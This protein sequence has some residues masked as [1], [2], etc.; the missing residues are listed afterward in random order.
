MTFRFLERAAIAGLLAGAGCLI[1]DALTH[2]PT[3]FYRYVP[4]LRPGR[5][6]WSHAEAL[7]NSRPVLLLGLL[8]LC[9][10]LLLALGIMVTVF[11]RGVMGHDLSTGPNTGS[12]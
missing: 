9:S 10:A 4:R 6:A 12:S 2:S 3:R 5:D 7:W 11:V 8:L 1:L